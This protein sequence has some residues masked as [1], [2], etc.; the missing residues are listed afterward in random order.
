MNSVLERLTAARDEDEL[1]SKA[2]LGQRVERF[3]GIA[4]SLLKDC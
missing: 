3:G 4:G 2:D 1:L